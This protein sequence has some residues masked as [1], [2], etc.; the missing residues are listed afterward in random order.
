M[1]SPSR[2]RKAELTGPCPRGPREEIPQERRGLGRGRGALACPG[3]PLAAAEAPL[4]TPFFLRGKKT[5][6]WPSLG[7]RATPPSA[8]DPPRKD[9]L[10]SSCLSSPG[11]SR[12]APVFTG[13]VPPGWLSRRLSR[14]G[15]SVSSFCPENRVG[16][17]REIPRGAGEVQTHPGERQWRTTCSFQSDPYR[18]FRFGILIPY[19]AFPSPTCL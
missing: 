7:D 17:H 2:L 10:P 9:P 12:A 15:E 18:I 13:V 8:R 3:G 6:S 11:T 16:D 5:R 14:A 1:L 4:R 19:V